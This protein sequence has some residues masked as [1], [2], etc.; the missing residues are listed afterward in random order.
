MKYLITKNN[1]TTITTQT[2]PAM[3]NGITILK[4]L[5]TIAKICSTVA[6]IG[7]ATPAVVAVEVARVKAVPAYIIP[8]L[9]PPTM[10]PKPHFSIGSKSGMIA[11][12]V[13]KVPAI[14]EAGVVIVS[15]I[16][17]TKGI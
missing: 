10:I 17:S 14:T 3:I 4:I 15:K 9:P 16:L 12:A 6:T 5:P 1:I 2:I 13:S 7:L 8:A 11:E